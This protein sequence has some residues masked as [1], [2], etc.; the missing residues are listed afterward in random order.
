[1]IEIDESIQSNFIS[2]DSK[3]ETHEPIPEYT[4]VIE[5]P[6]FISA[7]PKLRDMQAE[8]TKLIPLSVLRKREEKIP[9]TQIKRTVAKSEVVEEK[10]PADDN[11]LKFLDEVNKM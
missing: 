6:A 7:D 2:K 3:K 10:D 1:M 11:L 5:T 8:V 4:P 9:K